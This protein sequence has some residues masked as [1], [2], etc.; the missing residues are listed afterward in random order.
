M[1]ARYDYPP[2][3]VLAKFLRSNLPLAEGRRFGLTNLH[4]GP[5]PRQRQSGR[6]V[7]Q[8]PGKN[9]VVVSVNQE[10]DHLIS[11]LQARIGNRVPDGEMIDDLP[12]LRRQ[13]K[14]LVHALIKKCSDA[15]RP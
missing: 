3:Q 7:R 5:V 13:S 2:L 9:E 1:V 12:D 8:W 6:I 15:C 11:S 14:I 4:D 10:A